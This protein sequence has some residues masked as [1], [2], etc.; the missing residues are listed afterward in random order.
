MSTSP[1]VDLWQPSRCQPW[2]SSMFELA[3]E[4]H[5]S[6][7]QRAWDSHD[8]NMSDS[9]PTAAAPGSCTTR[10][11]TQSS[12]RACRSRAAVRMCDRE[13]SFAASNDSCGAARSTWNC[14]YQ[15]FAYVNNNCVALC[16]NWPC[17]AYIIW[18]ASALLCS[19]GC[20]QVRAREL[21]VHRGGVLSPSSCAQHIDMREL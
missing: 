2:T 19:R 11:R 9:A 13:F 16:C 17:D 7:S 14:A 3:A 5:A 4:T 8:G 21:T 1:S 20:R 15:G 18:R 10:R 6:T 12:T